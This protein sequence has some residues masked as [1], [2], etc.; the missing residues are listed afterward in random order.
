MSDELPDSAQRGF[1]HDAEAR[2]RREVQHLQAGNSGCTLDTTN[3]RTR[4]ARMADRK[5]HSRADEAPGESCDTLLRAAAHVPL[6]LTRTLRA[7]IWTRRSLAAGR[8]R[9][10]RRIGEGG[11]GLVY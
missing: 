8:L 9:M 5:E 2:R 10:R 6:E 11:M 1:S 7:P 3:A 4:S